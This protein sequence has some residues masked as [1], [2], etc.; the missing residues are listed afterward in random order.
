M[1][2][3]R[4]MIIAG[5]EGP[6]RGG[7]PVLDV[8][9]SI[10]M[11]VIEIHSETEIEQKIK[12]LRNANAGLIFPPNSFTSAHRQQIIELVTRLHLPSIYFA[13]FF[14]SD[15]GLI[16]YGI[17]QPH[18]FRQAGN[19]VNRILRGTKPADLPAQ[20]PSKFELVI[21]LKTAKALGLDMPWFLQQRADEVIE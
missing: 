11:T 20:S 12:M 9:L 17:D 3:G 8:T 1:G 14:V 21:N 18:Q 16:S 7:S 2:R 15:G 10:S 4:L 6:K 5:A 19:Y 13:R